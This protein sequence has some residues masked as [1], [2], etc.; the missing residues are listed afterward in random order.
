VTAVERR[1][2]FEGIQ[3]FRD[4]GGYPTVDGGSV[5]WRQVFR[6]DALHKLTE[7]DVEAFGRLG[8]RLLNAQAKDLLK[9]ARADSTSSQLPAAKTTSPQFH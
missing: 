4:L 3:N 5:R 6:A 7:P 2:P 1:L 9:S 8:M